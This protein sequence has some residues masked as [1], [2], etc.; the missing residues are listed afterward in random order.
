MSYRLK[1]SKQTETYSGT[2][3][4]APCTVILFPVRYHEMGDGKTIAYFKRRTKLNGDELRTEWAV[5]VPGIVNSKDIG[6]GESE[7]REIHV[8]L[9]QKPAYA[10]KVKE[11]L[12]GSI[13]IDSDFVYEFW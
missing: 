3:G 1:L 13:Q 9:I 7:G 8:D 12:K 11:R 2:R 6:N 5:V 10:I 4:G